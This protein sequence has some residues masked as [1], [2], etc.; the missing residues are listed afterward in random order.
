[1]CGIAGIFAYRD[2]AP[3]VDR[4]ELMRIRDHMAARGP[5]GNGVWLAGDGRIGLG[6]RRLAIIDLCEAGAQPMLS[7]GGALIIT[8]NGEIYNYREL[9]AELAARR[10]RLP[11]RVRHRGAAAAL[12]RRRRGDGARRC[13]AC[14]PSPS[15]TPRSAALFLA[16]DRYGIKPL[17]YADDGWTF[18]FASQVKALLAGG[19]VSREPDPAGI[20]GLPSVRQRARAVHDLSRDPCAAGRHDAHRSTPAGRASRSATT[21]SSPSLSPSAPSAGHG[22]RPSAPAAACATRVLDSVRHHLVADVPVGV[23]LSAGIDSGALVGL[24]RDAGTRDIRAVTLAFEEFRGTLEDEAPLAAEVARSATA[25]ATSCARVDRARVRARPAAH[26]RRHGP[27]DH[28]RRQHLVRRQGRAARR[29]SRSRSRA[30]AATSCFGGYPIFLDVPRWVGAWLRRRVHARARRA[31]RAC[32]RRPSPRG[33][34]AQPEGRRHAGVRRQLGRRVPAAPRPLHAVG[35]RRH[36]RSRHG[37]RG[38]AP[39]RRRCS[40]SRGALRADARSTTSAASPRSKPRSTCATSCCA[41]PTGPAWRT[42]SRCACPGR[43][44]LLRRPAA[45]HVAGARSAPRTRWPTSPVT[46]LPAAVR[47]RR[48]TGFVTPVGRWLREAAGTP[49]GDAV[50]FSAASRSWALRVWRNDWTTPVVA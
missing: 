29:A 1:M 9:R 6:H 36:A 2:V 28:R 18:R 44:V 13:A 38:P 35:A 27:A 11:Q 47:E 43:C 48:K 5:D 21:R 17:Y 34:G 33:L 40:T 24:M 22:D 49:A 50:D 37:A 23:F 8:F 39:A 45:R 10:L 32:C 46:P 42:R 7:A 26:P 15:G 30:S 16:R 12:R 19:A 25:R 3:A 4:D 14:S 31:G 20:V 41:T